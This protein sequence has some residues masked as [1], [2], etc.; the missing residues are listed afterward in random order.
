[1]AHPDVE[2]VRM[3]HQLQKTQDGIKIIQGLANAHKN[4]IGNR[5]AGVELGEEHLIEHL[6][7]RQIPYLAADGGSAEGAAHA[8][9]HLGG[10]THSIPVMVAHQ[11]GFHTVSVREPPEVFY[12]AVQPGDLLALH[13]GNGK[14]AG[15]RQLLPQGLGKIGHFIEGGRA[16]VEPLKDLLGA[17]TGFTQ[18]GHK[19]DQLLRRHRFDISQGSP[20]YLR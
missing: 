8:A 20:P 1:M 2:P 5:K 19:A 15:L 4:D 13:L 16:P 18:L 3:V 6:G 10:D 9:A 17:K 12:G 7:G 14:R 11:N